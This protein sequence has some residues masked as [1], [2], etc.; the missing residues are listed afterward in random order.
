MWAFSHCE[1]ERVRGLWRDREDWHPVFVW[2][3]EIV[4]RL[5]VQ[6]V[7]RD[8]TRQ[9]IEQYERETQ[10]AIALKRKLDAQSELLDSYARV[11]IKKAQLTQLIAMNKQADFAELEYAP[12]VEMDEV[13][14]ARDE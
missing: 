14:R 3:P 10:L 7:V 13:W 12:S 11:A 8:E 1:L 5:E 6:H 9:R 4:I 2:V